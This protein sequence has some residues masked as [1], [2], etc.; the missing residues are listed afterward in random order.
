MSRSIFSR[1]AGLFVFSLFLNGCGFYPWAVLT[2]DSDVGRT[3]GPPYSMRFEAKKVENEYYANLHGAERIGNI[4][5]DDDYREDLWPWYFDVDDAAAE[6]G[7][8]FYSI[9]DR[10]HSLDECEC[11]LYR[12]ATTESR[13]SFLHDEGCRRLRLK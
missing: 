4:R 6:Y 10:F 3:D 7:A 13:R 9:T 11:I 1:L 5:L 12:I 2:Y 8:D